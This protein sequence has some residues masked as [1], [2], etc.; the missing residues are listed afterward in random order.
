MNDEYLRSGID[1]VEKVGDIKSIIRGPQTMRCPN[2]SI[3]SWI[4]LP[5]YDAD[6]G[7][8]RPVFMRPANIVH[9]GKVYIIPSPTKDGSL[10]LATRLETPHMKRFGNLL[11][12]SLIV[13]PL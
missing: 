5:L 7:W 1:Y 4:W 9:E 10:T 11:T 8:G 2:L 3:N 13:S 6:F 12:N